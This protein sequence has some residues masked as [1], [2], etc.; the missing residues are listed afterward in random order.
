MS[1]HHDFA[2]RERCH[3]TLNMHR[4]GVLCC[5]MG[6]THCRIHTL[7]HVLLSVHGAA[8]VEDIPLQFP[9]LH[10][11]VHQPHR[12]RSRQYLVQGCVPTGGADVVCKVVLG[13]RGGRGRGGGVVCHRVHPRAPVSTFASLNLIAMLCDRRPKITKSPTIEPME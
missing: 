1:T 13:G 11:L 8:P 4:G 9:Q 10:Q 3:H 2:T 5:V 12:I 6:P 7:A